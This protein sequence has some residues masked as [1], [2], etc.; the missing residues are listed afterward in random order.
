MY[1]KYK[2]HFSAVI[3]TWKHCRHFMSEIP[4]LRAVWEG[5]LS[6][7]SKHRCTKADSWTWHSAF[8]NHS[9]ISFSHPFLLIIMLKLL[10]KINW[11]CIIIGNSQFSLLLLFILH[12]TWAALSNEIDDRVCLNYETHTVNQKPTSILTWDMHESSSEYRLFISLL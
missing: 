10:N 5:Y 4:V 8:T 6:K 7:V 12:V 9:S 3:L 1:I 11:I 2:V